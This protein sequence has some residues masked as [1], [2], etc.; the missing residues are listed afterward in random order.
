M[1]KVLLCI[2]A[3][4]ALCSAASIR[5]R[6]YHFIY[7]P[8]TWS[9]AQ[10][11][12]RQT[13]TDL[14]TVDSY[15]MVTT[16]NSLADK[17]QMSPNTDAWI[18]LYFDVIGWKWSLSDK[19]FYKNKEAAFTNWYPGQPDS[20]WYSEQCAHMYLTDGLW[21]D[22]YCDSLFYSICSNVSG[23]NVNFVFINNLMNWTDAQRYCRQHYTDL[24]SVRNMSEN[25]QIRK[26]VT[27]YTWIGL[28]KNTWKWSNGPLFMYNYWQAGEPDGGN[29]SCTTANFANS[30]RWVDRTCGVEKPFICYHDPEPLWRTV[31]KVKLV[32][33]SALDL[34]DPAVQEDLLQQLK[35]KLMK[36][37]VSGGVKL[38]WKKKP[39]GDVFY[40][41]KKDKK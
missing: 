13:Y 36:Q 26:Q 32:K 28:Y 34:K 27:G 10:T 35:Q 33:P 41:D 40:R 39:N 38:S 16:L 12:C 37:N 21:W 14:V 6:R 18:G 30:G 23:G 4:S 11:Y 24:A 8:K 3:A 5:D 22:Y 17:T 20:I 29:E 7:D 15:S 19:D 25:E 1:E 2:I 9:D 31:I